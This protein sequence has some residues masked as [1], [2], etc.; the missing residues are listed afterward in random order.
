MH[1]QI[2]PEGDISDISNRTQDARRGSGGA[3]PRFR[4]DLGVARRWVHRD[5]APA[6]RLHAGLGYLPLANTPAEHTAQMKAMVQRW[7]EV[8][9][10]A[11]VRVD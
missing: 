5:A 1:S 11:G 4:T 3:A 10:K 6:E 8:I 2:T 7:A 9:E